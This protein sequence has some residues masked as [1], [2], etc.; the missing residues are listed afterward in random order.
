MSE[1]IAGVARTLRVCRRAG[2]TIIQ[3]VMAAE[4]DQK[5]VPGVSRRVT[6]TGTSLA[7]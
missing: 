7:T 4:I 5:W 3:R 6:G 1:L 2:L